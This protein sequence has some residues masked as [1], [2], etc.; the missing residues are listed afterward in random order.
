MSNAFDEF[1]ERLE[2]RIKM[3]EREIRK[4][5]EEMFRGFASFPET[6]MRV[7]EYS[8]TIEPLY[9][10]RDLGDRIVVYIDLP[11]LAEGSVDI[12]FEG[13]VMHISAKLR[14]SIKLDN[15]SRRYRGI[16]VHEYRA[17][18]EL[19][20]EPKPEKTKIRS[21]KGIVEITIYK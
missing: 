3:L 8:E 1:F 6:K 15:W 13:R 20:I 2:K 14:E 7:P 10:I 5:F 17:S 9:T 4:S 21:R 16:E 11:Y 19:P 18:I 12:R